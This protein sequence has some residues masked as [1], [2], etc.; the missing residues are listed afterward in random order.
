MTRAEMDDEPTL[1]PTIGGAE[2]LAAEDDHQPHA[3]LY[4]PD[5]AD[6]TG[7][8]THRVPERQAERVEPRRLGFRR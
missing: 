2:V 5:L 7:W 8:N 1:T 3:F 4:V 6:R